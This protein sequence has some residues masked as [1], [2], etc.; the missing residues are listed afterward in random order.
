[1][2]AP[3]S[4]AAV[5]RYS[6]R[7]D[8]A[9]SS[10]ARSATQ[11]RSQSKFTPIHL[12]GLVQYES[13]CVQTGVDPAQLGAQ[14]GD[15]RMGGVDVQ[16]DPLAP[17]DG[18]QLRDGVEGRGRRGADRG[19]HEEGPAPGGAILGDGGLQR[20]GPH[21]ERRVVGDDVQV[22]GADAR[23]AHALL[24]RRVG[25]RGRVGDE[26]AGH[27]GGVHRALR[28]PLPRR[29]DG[30]EGGL[31]RRALDD[32][33]P[34]PVGAEPVGQAEQLGHPVEHERLDLG[35]GRARGP[36]HAVHPEAGR[37]QVTQDRR[38]A[39]VG[40]EVGE[41]AGV[42]P[43]GQAGDDDPI[44]V[45]EHG[46]E[47]LGLGRGVGGELVAHPAGLGRGGDGEPLDPLE[48]VGD[49]VD[50]RVALLA[51][52][53]GGH[54]GERNE[55]LAPSRRALAAGSGTARP[56]RSRSKCDED[57][58]WVA[59]VVRSSARRCSSRRRG[60]SG[61]PDGRRQVTDVRSMVPARASGPAGPAGACSRRRRA[62]GRRAGTS[63]GPVTRRSAGRWRPPARRPASGRRGGG[64]DVPSGTA[65]RGCRGRPGPAG[66]RVRRSRSP[67][68]PPVGRWPRGPRRRAR[69]ARPSG[70]SGRSS[71]GA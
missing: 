17:A 23:D 69:S 55:R 16:P 22:V 53:L 19:A 15:A 70:A 46:V 64:W 59:R 37:G 36:R 51:E 9:P 28:R 10:A 7:I 2:T 47:G 52:V 43:V 4:P 3:A 33:A 20:V 42:L 40:G 6:G 24:D 66:G 71:D 41:E 62:A 38:I 68:P 60:A 21:G 26:I 32:T 54:A 45:G 48:V 11:N 27:T 13:T 8:S 34:R 67:R 5:R 56:A 44:E 65:A 18:G 57:A 50:E 61:G 30:A 29:E 35:A 31:G 12:C 14:R 63:G 58:P 49:P 39:G 1:M 25:L